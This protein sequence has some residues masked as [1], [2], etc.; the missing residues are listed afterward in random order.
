VTDVSEELHVSFFTVQAT[1]NAGMFI[2]L[3]GNITECNEVS[4]SSETSVSFTSEELPT[5]FFRIEVTEK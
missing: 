1:E 2:G 4:T 3:Y 5:S